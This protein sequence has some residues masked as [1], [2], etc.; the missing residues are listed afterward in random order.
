MSKK[1]VVVYHSGFGHTARQ[2]EHVFNGVAAVDGVD[3]LRVSV[4]NVDAHW[5]DLAAA[6]RAKISPA[7]IPSVLRIH[8]NDISQ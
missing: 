4:E 3:A 2:A 6:D 8:T 5:D 7:R 1:V